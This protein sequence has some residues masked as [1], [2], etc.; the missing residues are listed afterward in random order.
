M[1]GSETFTNLLSVSG[2]GSITGA[3]FVASTAQSKHKGRLALITMTFL[4][5]IIVGF[6]FSRNI[7]LTAAL[8]FVAGAALIMV[9]ALITSLVQLITPDDLRGR[10]MSVYNV[11]FRGGMPMGSLAT[12]QLIPLFTAPPVLAA[13]GALLAALG[14]WYLLVH[15]KVAQL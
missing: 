9:F 6:S 4:G 15:R 2:L 14:L 13:N 7:W 12:G 8:V 11:A 10:V 1:R 3:L 5:L